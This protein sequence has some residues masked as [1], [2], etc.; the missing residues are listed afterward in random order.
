MA[1]VI[2]GTLVYSLPHGDDDDEEVEE[3]E[4]RS[5]RSISN[6]SMGGKTMPMPLIGI[7]SSPYATEHKQSKEKRHVHVHPMI[8]MPHRRPRAQSV[9]YLDSTSS[10]HYGDSL[11]GGLGGSLPTRGVSSATKLLLE[12]CRDLDS[13]TRRS[14][15]QSYD[16]MATSNYSTL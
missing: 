7:G 13:Y 11:E 12:D 8:H 4:T 2:T 16:S 1:Y 10:G 5:L 6:A 15:I 3:E 14:H 9:S